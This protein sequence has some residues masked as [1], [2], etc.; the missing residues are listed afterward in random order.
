MTG[1]DLERGDTSDDAPTSSGGEDE[2]DE[3]YYPAIAASVMLG[4]F[5]LAAVFAG[6]SP[7]EMLYAVPLAALTWGWWHWYPGLPKYGY[8]L[9]D[10]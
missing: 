7:F 4:W 2:L 5:P 10:L 6:G 8:A 9:Y 3:L 1:A